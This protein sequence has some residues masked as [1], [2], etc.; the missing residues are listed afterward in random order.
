MEY[1]AYV[2]ALMQLVGYAANQQ[3]QAKRQQ[4][5]QA[6]MDAY[7][8]QDLP[9]LEQ[10]VAEQVPP[11]AFEALKI[12]PEALAAQKETLANYN[13]VI[14]GNGLAAEDRAAINRVGNEV[15]RAGRGARAGIRQTMQSAGT[16]GSGQD[17]AAQLAQG[18]DANDRLAQ[19]GLDEKSLALKNRLAAISGK[20]SLAGQMRSQDFSEK[21]A[22]ASAIDTTNRM[23]AQ[24]RQ[25]ANAYNA[26]IPQTLY[27][28]QL[29]KLQGQ[30]GAGAPLA[31][32]YNE[33][34]QTAQALAG[35]VGRTFNEMSAGSGGAGSAAGGGGDYA[36]PVPTTDEYDEAMRQY[37]KSR[38]NNGSYDAAGSDPSEWSNPYGS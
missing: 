27:E 9:K 14:S 4:L 36:G 17:V 15:D 33:Q 29:Q 34:G 20:G 10:M 3:Q 7:K 38:R 18:Q 6:A 31:S 13:D 1:G 8:N 25:G 35:G 26:G 21:A 32:F 24:F 19:A 28:D 2:Q 23:N 37:L 22:K 30:T 12:D 16:L 5:L 11:S